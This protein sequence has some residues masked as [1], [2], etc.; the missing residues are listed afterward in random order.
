VPP[1]TSLLL[2]AG[3]FA[4]MLIWP[5]T[6]STI[7]PSFRQVIRA[8]LA[9]KVLIVFF[10]YLGYTA[11]VVA[12]AAHAGM[13]N[14]DLLKDTAITTLFVGLPLVGQTLL[15]ARLDLSGWLLTTQ[16]AWSRNQTGD[17]TADAPR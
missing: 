3:F 11:G 14:F 13:W 2:L 17:S 5:K 6:R 1:R 4:V 8:L 9:W 7:L 16:F 10:V 12:L 15:R